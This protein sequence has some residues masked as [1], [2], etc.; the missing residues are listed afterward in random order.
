MLPWAIQGLQK[1]KNVL[2][3]NFK[4]Q[5]QKRLFQIIIKIPRVNGIFSSAK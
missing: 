3:S 5:M 1:L 2:S 4:K